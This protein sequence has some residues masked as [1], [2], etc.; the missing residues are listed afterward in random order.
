MGTTF[1]IIVV[2]DQRARAAEAAAAAFARIHELNG[3]LSD[4]EPESELS[5]LAGAADGQAP[6][7]WI[8]LSEELFTV[9]ERSRE[10]SSRTAGAFDVTVGPLVRLWRRAR[11]QG[12]LPAERR[13]EEALESVGFEHL[14]LDAARRAARLTVRG[15]RLDL[16]G[17]AKGYALDQAREVL[18]RH[19]FTRVLLDGGGDVLLGE[20]PPG[21]AGW[22]VEIASPGSALRLELEN[23]AVATSG[24]LERFVEIEGVRYS[25]L[26]DPRSGQ[27]LTERL[28]VSVVARTGLAADAWAS[29]LSVLGVERGFALL[30]KEPGVEARI[31]GLAGQERGL[32]RVSRTPGFPAGVSSPVR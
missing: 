26:V 21:C 8:P 7:E 20:A 16:G 13:I 25:H 30:S 19:G 1:R 11:R 6:T 31:V 27:G 18:A 9:L 17:I 28:L 3:I 29:S 10:Q 32:V 15:M 4:Y 12:E 24:D 5:R 22:K 14:E 2:A 23:C